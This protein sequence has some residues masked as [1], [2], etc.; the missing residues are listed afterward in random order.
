MLNFTLY[1]FIALTTLS[2]LA[3]EVLLAK[4]LGSTP[5]DSYLKFNLYKKDPLP[6]PKSKTLSFFDKKGF[7]IFNLF[8][9]IKD[10]I[11]K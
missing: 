2:P 10:L 1:S 6:E 4:S 9:F 11:A 5:K 8:L 3:S 7:I